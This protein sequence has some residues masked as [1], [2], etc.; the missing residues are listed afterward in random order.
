MAGWIFAGLGI[1]LL[2]LLLLPVV[3]QAEYDGELTVWVRYVF[4]RRQI[5]PRPPGKEKPPEGEKASPPQGES[6][7]KPQKEKLS[8]GELFSLSKTILEGLWPPLRRLL[9]TVVFYDIFF[10]MRVAEEDAAQT[11]ISCGRYNA[12]A[13]GICG[14]LEN[15]FQIKRVKISIFPDFTQEESAVRFRGKVRVI[16]L[17]ALAAGI[18]AFISLLMKLSPLSLPKGKKEGHHDP[19]ESTQ[20]SKGGVTI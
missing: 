13:F 17:A 11:A 20:Q 14:F 12:A 5:L 9:K 8:A 10:G 7:K 18:A 1:L 16:P 4:L 15:F 2:C 6:T 3:F 19:K